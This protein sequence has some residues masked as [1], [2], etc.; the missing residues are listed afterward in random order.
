LNKTNN[1]LHE[2]HLNINP[3]KQTCKLQLMYMYVTFYLKSIMIKLNIGLMANTIRIHNVQ[4]ILPI[5]H[6]TTFLVS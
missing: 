2:D 6:L 3:C 5:R 1:Y 4:K